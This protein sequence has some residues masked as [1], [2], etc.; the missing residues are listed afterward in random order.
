MDIAD[1]IQSPY[2]EDITDITGYR[3]DITEGF[4][5]SIRTP[6]IPCSV[7]LTRNNIRIISSKM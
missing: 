5:E 2:K 4:Y 1:T 7:I 6:K 3:E